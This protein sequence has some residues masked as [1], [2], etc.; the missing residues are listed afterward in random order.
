[1]KKK[2]ARRK[3][4]KARR[5]PR[6]RTQA[7]WIR[8][9]EKAGLTRL[10]EGMDGARAAFRALPQAEQR[11]LA[12]EI[13]ITRRADLIRAHVDVIGVNAGYRVRRNA[14]NR[15]EIQPEVCV[16]LLVKQKKQKA[17]VPVA[18]RVPEVLLAYW[19]V[20]D[21]R[22]LCAVPTDVEDAKPLRAIRPLT[23]V[24]ANAPGQPESAPGV[25][26]CA[27]QM[28]GRIY[29]IS[30]RHVFGM[31]LRPN[32]PALDAS[33]I[34]LAGEAQPVARA[35]EHAGALERGLEFSFDSQLAEVTD[36]ERLRPVLRR[37]RYISRARGWDDLEGGGAA[38]ILTG[39]GPILARYARQHTM[40]VDYT[41]DLEDIRHE[42]VAFFHTPAGSPQPGDSGSPIMTAQ[43]GGKLLGMLIAGDQETFALAI[44]A[45]QLLH[46]TRYAGLKPD[47]GP[48]EFW[49]EP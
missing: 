30:C 41:D 48:W 23:R 2:G 10:P 4:P 32:P 8:H 36:A 14:A 44:P 7:E 28:A 27:V 9:V 11:K 3:R 40:P 6:R 45:W 13:A 43:D 29:A 18:R 12:Q 42:V 39:R 37:V 34:S 26:A 17:R 33:E 22:V 15:P 31:A 21:R 1:V 25:I 46:P 35:T 24:E 38:W 16:T 49:P 47:D 20:G 5:A 19:T